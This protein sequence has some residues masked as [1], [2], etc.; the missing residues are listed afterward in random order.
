[1]SSGLGNT[2]PYQKAGTPLVLGAG[3]H[4]LKYVSKAITVC[5]DGGHAFVSFGGDATQMKI[6]NGTCVRLEVRC[7]TLTLSDGDGGNHVS[8][9]VEL[10]DIPKDSLDPDILSITR[11]DLLE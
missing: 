4:N 11:A 6:A 2:A 1:M 10:T 8:A 3:T 5:C 9:V 7:L